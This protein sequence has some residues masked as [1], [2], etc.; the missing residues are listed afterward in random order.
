M[1]TNSH[2][3]FKWGE[4]L[5]HQAGWGSYLTANTITR[6]V[7]YLTFYYLYHLI[8]VADLP[9]CAT[10]RQ[11]ML[12]TLLCISHQLFIII[13]LPGHQLVPSLE[14]LE[15]PLSNP[16]HTPP[17]YFLGEVVVS[18][19]ALKADNNKIP[20]P[21]FTPVRRGFMDRWIIFT[22]IKVSRMEKVV[23]D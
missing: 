11:I 4:L 22:G 2:T 19:S 12:H 5:N 1:C 13:R 3:C 20:L 10:K 15:H 14:N 6:E 16:I 17:K 7:F 23:L 21:S 9:V 18:T 8:E